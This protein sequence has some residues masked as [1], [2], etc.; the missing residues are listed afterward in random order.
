MEEALV[1]R[2]QFAFKAWRRGRRLRHG[3][4]GEGKG[5]DG[6]RKGKRDVEK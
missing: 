2:R 3:R 6:R 4:Q 1:C 5:E